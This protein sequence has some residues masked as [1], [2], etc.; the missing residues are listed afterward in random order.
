MV[1]VGLNKR[2]RACRHRTI[3]VR[4]DKSAGRDAGSFAFPRGLLQL[5]PADAEVKLRSAALLTS[6]V[7]PRIPYRVARSV[8]CWISLTTSVSIT[9]ALV[10][11]AMQALSSTPS[12]K[13]GRAFQITPSNSARRYPVCAPIKEWRVSSSRGEVRKIYRI[14]RISH[15]MD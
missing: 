7:L 1:N 2:A 15:P 5:G 13:L 3:A 9:I 8:A 6:S 12:G 4:D 11:C 14:E 10:L